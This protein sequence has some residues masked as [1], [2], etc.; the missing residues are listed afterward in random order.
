[1]RCKELF[2][3]NVTADLG[4]SQFAC[5]NLI[6]DRFT[7]PASPLR[8]FE[9]ARRVEVCSHYP[10][11]VPLSLRGKWRNLLRKFARVRFPGLIIQNFL[12][13]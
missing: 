4:N 12:R 1:M 11:K 8:F 13:A 6:L 5:Q 3:T 2:E 10:W 9:D 7:C